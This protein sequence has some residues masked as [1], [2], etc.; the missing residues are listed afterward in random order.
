MKKRTGA[1]S[2]YIVAISTLLFTIIAM[3]FAAVVISE[4]SRT[5][6]SDLSQSAYDSALA[7]IEDA[8]IAITN[9]QRCL[10]QGYS[11]ASSISLASTVSCEEIIYYMEHPDCDMVGHILNRIPKGEQTEVLVQETSTISGNSTNDMEQAYTCVKISKKNPDYRG[12][13]PAGEISRL[14]PLRVS[15]A[16]GAKSIRIKWYSS[17]N[18]KQSGLNLNTLTNG[19]LGF[20]KAN[21]ASDPP[22]MSVQLIQ[23]AQDFTLDELSVSHITSGVYGTSD[24]GLITLV[25]TNIKSDQH[26]RKTAQNYLD[27]TS[28]N[29]IMSGDATNFVTA[30]SKVAKNLPVLVNCGEPGATGQDAEFSCS[31][32]IQIPRP[33]S[34][35]SGD[36][37]RN[38][39]T[40]MLVL[41]IPYGQPDTDFAVE[42][43]T[44][45]NCQTANR[46]SFLNQLNV[47]STGRA[48]DLYR[49]VEARVENIADDAIIPRFAMQ[50]TN[51]D[52]SL[53]KLVT[54]PGL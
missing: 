16:D 47:D 52:T 23:T 17:E 42:V 48:N 8:K 51:E 26:I 37:T 22:I 30:N 2:F 27:V 49:R 18:R 15:N 44:D 40:F 50:L 53:E 25:P 38:P 43:C 28:N 31:V 7:G 1:A 45:T 29:S 14:V 4:L 20:P 46:L 12:T 9:Y 21:A 33:V 13:I 5:V 35:S 36:D 3:S 39:N 54:Y 10:D 11:A 19:Y 41:S 6:N 24:S 34:T 32:S